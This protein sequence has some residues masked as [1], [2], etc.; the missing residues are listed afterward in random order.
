MLNF[1]IFLYT[2]EKKLGRSEDI[3][4]RKREIKMIRAML[5]KAM[6]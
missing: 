6:F 1:S 2:W 4:H 3:E 5:Q